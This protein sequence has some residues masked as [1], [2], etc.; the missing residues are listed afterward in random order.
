MSGYVQF[1]QVLGL[2]ILILYEARSAKLV[3]ELSCSG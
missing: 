3:T 2:K 1:L